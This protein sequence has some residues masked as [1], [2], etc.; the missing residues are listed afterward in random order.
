MAKRALAGASGGGGDKKPQKLWGGAFG[1]ATDPMMEVFNNS[2]PFDKKLWAADI[3]GS[4]AYAKQLHVCGVLDD[5]QAADMQT[6]LDATRAEWA[7]GGFVVVDG[8]EDI[9]T[10]NERRLGEHVGTDTAGRLHTGRSRN[11]Q[12]ATDLKLWL[13]AE[14]RD[15]RNDLRALIESA[16]ASAAKD[17]SVDALLPGYTH[18]QRAQ[19]IRWSH[20]TLAHAWAWTRDADRLD[21][22]W[23]RSDV[24]PLGSGALAG[25]PFFAASDRDA[26]AD[27]LGF[28][29][30]AT[31]NSLDAVSDRDSAVEFVQWAAL[32][33]VHLSRWAEDLIIYGTREFG[34]VSFGQ[35]YST[36][37]SLMPQK[38]NPDALELLRGEASRGIP[39][40]F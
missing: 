1:E 18:L 8:D 20:W 10:A 34:F 33:G 28:R 19:P 13:R 26:L 23:R 22:L 21:A 16:R 31:P 12:V 40:D 7:S 3:R 27:A 4:K 14:V 38:R 32:T 9:H 11:D 37:S 5:A 2:L 17:E 29:G 24:C 6:G 39:T 35:A 25:H 30:G 36:G 15:L